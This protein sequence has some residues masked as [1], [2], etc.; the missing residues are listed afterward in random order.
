MHVVIAILGAL[1]AGFWAFAYFVGSVREG[2]DAVNDVRGLFRS[3]KWSRQASARVI[4]NLSD[5]REAAAVLLYQMAAYDGAVTDRQRAKIVSEMRQ[6]FNADPETGEGLYAFARAAVGQV[7]D[8]AN[9]LR[10]IVRPI[11]D[12]CTQEEKRAFVGM[13]EDVGEV[14]GPLTDAQRRLVA[15]TRRALLPAS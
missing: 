4:E 10:K 3:G 7:N 9:S 14:E 13:L 12:A 1:A 15:E 2:R 11:A 6:A 5:P 8:T